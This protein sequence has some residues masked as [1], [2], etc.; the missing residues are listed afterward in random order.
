[1]P[2]VHS[3]YTAEHFHLFH[4]VIATCLNTS[5]NLNMLVIGRKS[6]ISDLLYTPRIK[7]HLSLANYTLQDHIRTL[8][9]HP[10]LAI[11]YV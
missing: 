1:M 6:W 9:T 7:I 5:S 8:M 4:G 2:H 3:R 10:V 11:F